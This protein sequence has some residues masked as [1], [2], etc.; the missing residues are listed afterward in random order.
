MAAVQRTDDRVAKNKT[1]GFCVEP[2]DSRFLNSVLHGGYTGAALDSGLSVANP[3][4]EGSGGRSLG[5]SIHLTPCP[6]LLR[7]SCFLSTFV[8]HEGP[9][10]EE[11][12]LGNNLY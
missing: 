7:F 12:H 6:F 11:S 9:Y 5:P 8:S 4:L 10:L 1:E 3:L 2:R